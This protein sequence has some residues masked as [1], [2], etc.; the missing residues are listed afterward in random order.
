MNK[1]YTKYKA[2]QLLSDDYFLESELHPTGKDR[3]F[4]QQLQAENAPLAVEI[5]AARFFLKNIKVSTD[6]S[7]LSFGEQKIYG[8]EFRLPTSNMTQRKN[9]SVL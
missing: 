6:S 9:E 1:D 4:W 5:E 2:H 8:K 3:L 7:S